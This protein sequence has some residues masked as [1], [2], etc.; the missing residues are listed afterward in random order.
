[1]CLFDLTPL[2]TN[3]GCSFVLHKRQIYALPERHKRNFCQLSYYI[4]HF[5]PSDDNVMIIS[6]SYYYLRNTAIKSWSTA[7][8]FY[9]II[10]LVSFVR[11][12]H[13]KNWTWIEIKFNKM[14]TQSDDNSNW[15]WLRKKNDEKRWRE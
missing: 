11:Q 5:W 6:D 1:M 10:Y 7:E 3:Q 13:W 9:G 4:P 14:V 12:C 2:L 15:N 8:C